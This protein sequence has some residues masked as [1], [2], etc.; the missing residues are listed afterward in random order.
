MVQG[1]GTYIIFRKSAGCTN[2][3]KLFS[4]GSVAEIM[5]LNIETK[6]WVCEITKDRFSKISKYCAWKIFKKMEKF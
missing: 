2:S 4:R 6:Y 1:S 5:D 3:S